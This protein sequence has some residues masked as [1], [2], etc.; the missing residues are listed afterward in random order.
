MFL[1][2][3][4]PR[5]I[6]TERRAIELARMDIEACRQVRDTSHP[7]EIYSPY[8][9]VRAKKSHLEEIADRLTSIAE[10]YGY[11]EERENTR[12]SDIKMGIALTELMQ[13]TPVEAS[14]LD[15][16]HFM[17]CVLVPDLVAWRFP[18]HAGQDA[19]AVPNLERWMTIRRRERNCF[20]RLWWRIYT[21]RV[22][23][24]KKSYELVEALLEDEFIQIMERPLLRG[25]RELMEETVRMLLKTG[26]GL[27]GITR[28]D[29]LREVL[30]RLM[31]L[32]SIVDFHALDRDQLMEMLQEMFS[33]ALE[34][35]Q[36][37]RL[38][39]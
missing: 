2:P 7:K 22:E 8:K 39:A 5:M 14:N 30:K 27:V 13:I 21:L 12:E 11:P 17:T 10:D 37:P 24:V 28:A 23:G 25:Y 15:V 35:Q 20:G 3:Q 19:Q 29:L 31:R 6:D 9:G 4:L 33:Q 32:G 36:R 1:Y 18:F 26:D 16:W 34:A 38:I